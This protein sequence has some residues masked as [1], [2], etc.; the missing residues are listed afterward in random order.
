MIGW[1]GVFLGWICCWL[2]LPLAADT[3]T[4][5]STNLTGLSSSQLRVLQLVGRNRGGGQWT[6]LSSNQLVELRIKAELADDIIRKAHLPGGLVASVRY[7]D[8]N[9]TDPLAYENLDLSGAY[10]GL[11]LTASTFRYAVYREPTVLANVRAALEGIELLLRSSGRP[12]YL[13]RFAGLASE[14]A[15]KAFYS[16]WGGEDPSRPGF[17]KL[18][19][20]GESNV[21]AYVWLGGP[22]REVYAGINL[23]LASVFQ[24]V[25]E[26]KIRERMTNIVDQMMTRLIADKW[27]LDDGHGNL[28]FAPPLLTMALLRTAASV[29]PKK[30]ATLYQAQI[31]DMQTTH[32]GDLQPQP[33]LCLYCDYQDSVYLLA[34][35]M[36]LSRLEPDTS[37]AKLYFQDRLNQ[38]YRASSYQLNPWLA[39]SYVSIFEHAPNDVASRSVL[40]GLLYQFPIPR[41]TTAGLRDTNAPIETQEANG[42][43]WA[44]VPLQL[45]QRA[46]AAFQW[47]VSPA[48]L[49]PGEDAWVAHPGIDFI[50]PFW[51]S[52]DA[53]VIPD[54]ESLAPAAAAANSRDRLRSPTNSP[55]K[56]LPNT[57]APPV[58]N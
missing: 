8:T 30:Y 43:V 24:I 33:G 53:N 52:R 2:G 10:T 23:G 42:S 58:K 37:P 12:G 31:A 7:A 47:E 25:R 11:Y 41:W 14:P 20:R 50:L 13:P 21:S 55:R 32:G 57:N 16:H 48:V 36:V 34:N 9:R 1:R 54:A 51:I 22:S 6:D 46:T 35:L 26:P 38:A 44:K 29:N 39:A 28:T 4:N 19:Y 27:R 17:G 56:T 5:A 18:A 15:Y 3:L 45:N 49:A 40:Q